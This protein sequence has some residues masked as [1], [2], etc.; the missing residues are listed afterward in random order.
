MDLLRRCIMSTG[1]LFMLL[2]ILP[3]AGVAQ[4]SVAIHLGSP[5]PYRFAAPPV[6][7]VIPGTYVYAVPDIGMDIFFYSGEWYRPHEGRWFKARSYDGPWAYCPDHR[8]PHA[9]A[10]LPPDL[11]R[12]PPGHRRIPYGQLKKNWAAWERDRHWDWDRGGHEGWNGRHEERR[13]E[14][15]EHFEGKPEREHGHG[16]HGHDRG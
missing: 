11:H 1:L 16:E 8:V 5:P 14:G 3:L 7:T 4:V 15:R 2:I 9:L 6:V 10:E 13:E 12:I